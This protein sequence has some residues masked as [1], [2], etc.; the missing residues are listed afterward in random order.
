MKSYQIGLDFCVDCRH[1]TSESG[2]REFRKRHP[3]TI[4]EDLIING[5]R[6]PTLKSEKE[7]SQ[8]ARDSWKEIIVIPLNNLQKVYC[9][10]FS[11]DYEQVPVCAKHVMAA[12]IDLEK[13][14]LREEIDRLSKQIYDDTGVMV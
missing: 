2:Y 13:E 1:E 5:V 4:G 8:E 7:W 10:L 11:V 9:C 3:E 14:P 6:I 12:A